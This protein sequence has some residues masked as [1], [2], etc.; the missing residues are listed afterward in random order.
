MPIAARL[1]GLV[2]PQ[3]KKPAANKKHNKAF[4]GKIGWKRKAAKSKRQAEKAASKKAQE[5]EAA[6]AGPWVGK[7]V[8]S[9]AASASRFWRNSLCTVVRQ[10]PKTQQLT[11]QLSSGTKR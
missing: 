3:K 6:L 1:E 8:V 7:A 10:D 11:L 2:P 4:L 5:E 9:I